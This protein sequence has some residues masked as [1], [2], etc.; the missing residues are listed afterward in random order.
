MFCFSLLSCRTSHAQNIKKE[1]FHIFMQDFSL[2]SN[3]QLKRIKFPLESISPTDDHNSTETVFLK[4]TEWLY[5]NLI[6]TAPYRIQYYYQ[7]DF[8]TPD[9]DERV[10]GLVGLSDGLEINYYFKRI[11]NLWYLVKVVNLST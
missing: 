8:N 7:F 4:K 9:T 10:V 11:D 5:R 1:N 3:F 2:D 6:G